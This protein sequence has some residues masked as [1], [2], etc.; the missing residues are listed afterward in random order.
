M[1]NSLAASSVEFIADILLCPFEATRR[2]QVADP[3]MAKL[4]LPVPA[5]AIIA[6]DGTVQGFS[7]PCFSIRSLHQIVVQDFA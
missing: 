3:A 6:K 4:L 7:F 5:K 1:L 2:R